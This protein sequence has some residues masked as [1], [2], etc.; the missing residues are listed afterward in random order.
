MTAISSASATGRNEMPASDTTVQPS[1][2]RAELTGQSWSALPQGN[3]S[4]GPAKRDAPVAG[5][6]V[7]PGSSRRVHRSAPATP[8]SPH[9]AFRAAA[10]RAAAFRAAAFR[11]AAR[12]M[13]APAAVRP[14]VPA[15]RMVS[16]RMVSSRMVSSRTVSSRTVSSRTVSSRTVSSRT[17][18]IPTPAR[19]TAGRPRRAARPSGGPRAPAPPRRKRASRG[20]TT[21]PRRAVTAWASRP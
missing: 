14:T 10:F 4:F 12:R 20:R 2:S 17:A 15:C 1:S 6:R 13:A 16:S 18:P 11:A 19:R 8:T 7:R 5:G 9:P 21:A 3:G